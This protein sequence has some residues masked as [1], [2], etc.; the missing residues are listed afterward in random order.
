MRRVVMIAHTFPPEGSAG[1]YRPLRFARHLPATGWAPHVVAAS[2]YVYE[3]YDPQLAERLPS[4]TR[5]LRVRARD[6]WL[7]LQAWRASRQSAKPSPP[8]DERTAV[9]SSTR[10]PLRERLQRVVQTLQDWQYH[11]DTAVTWIRPATA[12]VVDLC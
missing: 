7:A 12:A 10:R 8:P 1:A 11:P 5:V 9:R 4:E 6:P 3:R 2:K